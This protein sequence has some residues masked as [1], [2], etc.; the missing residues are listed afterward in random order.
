MLDRAKSGLVMRVQSVMDFY[1]I[2]ASVGHESVD[3]F[4]KG[5]SLAF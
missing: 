5:W 2:P 1:L 4:D 3:P